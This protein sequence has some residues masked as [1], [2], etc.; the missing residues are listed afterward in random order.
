[1]DLRVNQ[2]SLA[3]FEVAPSPASLWLLIR[4]ALGLS[5]FLK[6]QTISG[7]KLGHKEATRFGWVSQTDE[8]ASPSWLVDRPRSVR[9]H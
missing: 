3:I 4:R 5:S 6:G 2:R 1:M 9:D 8:S 7:A